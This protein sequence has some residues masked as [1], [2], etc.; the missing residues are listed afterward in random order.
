MQTLVQR[1]CGLDVHQATVVACLLIVLENGK[2][3]KQVRTF[4]TTRANS[5]AYA[6]G[7]SRKIARK[8]RWKARGCIGSQSTPFSKEPSRSWSLMHST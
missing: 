4:G 3:Q 8:W 2:V 1:G 5:L 6:N 7:C